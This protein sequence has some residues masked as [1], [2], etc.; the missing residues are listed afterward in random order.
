[1]KE[2][3]IKRSYANTNLELRKDADDSDIYAIPSKNQDEQSMKVY[4]YMIDLSAQLGGVYSAEHGTGKRKRND[5]EKCYGKEAV[6]MIRDSKLA[7]DPDLLLNK[8][9]IFN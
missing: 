6:N 8:G 9:N 1:M 4:D 2:I 7:V 3:S 5:F